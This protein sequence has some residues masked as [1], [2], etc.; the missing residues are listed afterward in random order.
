MSTV[1]ETQLVAR[2]RGTSRRAPKTWYWI[3]LAV[4]V[5]GVALSV[6]WG[7]TSVNDANERA[8]A[9]P[10]T[11]VPGTL[12]VNVTEPGDQMVYFTGAGDASPGSLRL[13]VKDPAG[14]SV[15]LTP[16]D[17]AVEVDMSGRL[18]RAV[19]TFAADTKG[20]YTV[21]S[22]AGGQR[23]GM[24]AVGDNVTAKVL[25]DVLGALAVLLVSVVAAVVIVIVTAVRRS[26]RAS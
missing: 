11:T 22:A 19:A 4:F 16:Y 5:M 9:F 13:R 18:G 3:A 23:D 7:V 2:P 20:G 1:S 21:T 14:V 24:I 25:P 17:L 15:P 6:V 10:R 8:S 26:S 12:T